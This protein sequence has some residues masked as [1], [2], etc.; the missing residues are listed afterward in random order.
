MG[1][2]GKSATEIPVPVPTISPS[3][4]SASISGSAGPT[5]ILAL[6]DS[7]H[8]TP[9]NALILSKTR[10]LS[11]DIF[12]IALRSTKSA[13]P[14]IIY[15]LIKKKISQMSQMSFPMQFATDRDD[16]SLIIN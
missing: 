8:T 12:H 7:V 16:C 15:V 4:R 6:W 1:Y 9:E 14:V 13:L 11:P 2:S 5:T 3:S 10:A